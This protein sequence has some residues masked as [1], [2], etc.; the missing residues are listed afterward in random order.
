MATA[1]DRV[2]RQ[3]HRDHPDQLWVGDIERHEAHS[4]RA[5]MKGHRHRPVAAGRSKLRAA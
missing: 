3:S 5:V 2:D 1:G 4:N